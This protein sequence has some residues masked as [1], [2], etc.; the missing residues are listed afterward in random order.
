MPMCEGERSLRKELH[1]K[2]GR[3]CHRTQTYWPKLSLTSQPILA[4]IRLPSRSASSGVSRAAPPGQLNCQLVGDARSLEGL[5]RQDGRNALGNEGYRGPRGKLVMAERPRT[6]DTIVI[7][8]LREHIGCLEEHTKGDVLSFIGPL[9]YGAENFIRVLV[10]QLHTNKRRAP[11]LSM[12]LE[13]EGGYSEVVERIVNT[14]RHHYR[15][16]D[17]IVP[18]YAM[19]AGTIL[20]MSGDAIFMDYY[21]VLGP[22]DPQT[23]N[24][25]GKRVAALGYLHKY[26]QLVEK[27]QEGKLTLVEANYLV[28][29]FDPGDLYQYEQARDLTERLLKDWLVKYNFR[30]LKL[31]PVVKRQ[32]ADGIAKILNDTD[33]WCSH[34]R[35][36][37]MR[38]LRNKLKLQIEDIDDDPKLREALNAYYILLR[39]YSMGALGRNVVFHTRKAHFALGSRSKE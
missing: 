1:R 35:G 26:N 4:R 10:E 14:L 30:R 16:I 2:I 31:S 19:S 20:V 25:E 33:E 38:V 3:R 17:F 24:R 32:R 37:P 8:E 27:S 9:E 28:Q 34:A 6:S 11:K 18:N 36:I 23:E 15:C 22:I 5:L 13:T 7:E 39:D 12:M 29:N 21:S